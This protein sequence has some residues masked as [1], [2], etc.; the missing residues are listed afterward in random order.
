MTGTL[1][2]EKVLSI[3][4]EMIGI[5][6]EPDP[7]PLLWHILDGLALTAHDVAKII[8]AAAIAAAEMSLQAVG[9]HPGSAR[10]QG[11]EQIRLMY[12]VPLDDV[13][14]WEKAAGVLVVESAN[15]LTANP[16]GEANAHADALANRAAAI[17]THSLE[18]ALR[19]LGAELHCMRALLEGDTRGVIRR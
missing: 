4:D 6:R 13:P 18:F 5:L 15:F 9:I 19:T 17:A 11:V 8:G 14:D 16:G 12:Q 3:I 2:D 10:D 1:T 7:D